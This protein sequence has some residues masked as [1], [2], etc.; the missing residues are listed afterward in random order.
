MTDKEGETEEKNWFER[1]LNNNKIKNE[2]SHV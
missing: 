1:S 2:G